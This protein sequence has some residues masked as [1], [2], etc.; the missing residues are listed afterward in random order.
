[1]QTFQESIFVSGGRGM[2]RSRPGLSPSEI[3][4]CYIYYDI[5]NIIYVIGQGIPQGMMILMMIFNANLL[6]MHILVSRLPT[7][8]LPSDDISIRYQWQ[9]LVTKFGKWF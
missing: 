9:K 1:M 6:H 7:P 4:N 3:C 2:L 5:Y 8:H